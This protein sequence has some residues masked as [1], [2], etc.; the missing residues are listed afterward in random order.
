VAKVERVLDSGQ[1]HQGDQRR[2]AHRGVESAKHLHPVDECAV[3]QAAVET[4]Q[5]FFRRRAD[6]SG[7]ERLH[8]DVDET[9]ALAF[10]ALAE[11]PN[12][13]HAEGTIAVVED[14]DVLV[15]NAFLGEDAR[16]RA[17]AERPGEGAWDS[18]RCV[19]V[20]RLKSKMRSSARSTKSA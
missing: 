12:L 2:E 4:I 7:V 11:Q 5:E 6:R 3:Q 19:I 16:L 8:G 9:D 14:F 13:P 20:S 18:N 15:G 17:I 1:S 10:V